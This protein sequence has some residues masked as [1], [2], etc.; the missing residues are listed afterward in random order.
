MKKAMMDRLWADLRP[1]NGPLPAAVC[2]RYLP[3]LAPHNDL[4]MVEPDRVIAQ[5]VH[6]PVGMRHRNNR[7]T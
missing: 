1:A 4:A 2:V 5:I 6:H 3:K 7:L